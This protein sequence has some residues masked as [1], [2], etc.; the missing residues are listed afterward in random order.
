MD[1]GR[2]TDKIWGRDGGLEILRGPHLTRAGLSSG[3]N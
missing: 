2:I 3:S 1:K